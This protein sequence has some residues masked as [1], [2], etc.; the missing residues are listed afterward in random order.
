MP[1]RAATRRFQHRRT[2]VGVREPYRDGNPSPVEGGNHPGKVRAWRSPA[3]RVIRYDARCGSK[4]RPAPGARGASRSSC[5]VRHL[6]IF[7]R[8]A[9]I[10]SVA[11]DN[12]NR[13]LATSSEK[14]AGNRAI[15]FVE[16][17]HP[18]WSSGSSQ[19]TFAEAARP[20]RA[21]PAGSRGF[22]SWMMA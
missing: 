14:C 12:A 19:V 10:P 15:H 17:A 1:Q 13:L 18:H 7:T 3:W 6:P 5:G 21:D 20:V 4:G 16:R 11:G 8:P 9:V 2:G 22:C